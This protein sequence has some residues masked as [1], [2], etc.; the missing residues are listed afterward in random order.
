MKSLNDEIDSKKEL[1]EAI[2]PV[3]YSYK[4]KREEIFSRTDKKELQDRLKGIKENAINHLMQ[5]KQEA[6]TALQNNG[7][8]V[9]EAKDAKAARKAI[10]EI[11]GDE[12][13]I[14][15]S[16]SNAANEIGLRDAL[17]DKDLIETDLGDFLVDIMREQEIHPVLPAIHLQPQKMADALFRLTGERVFPKPEAILA[18]ARKY[19]RGKITG[20]KVGISGANVITADGT[21]MILENEGNVSLVS[22]IP[23][24]HIIITGFEKIAPTKEDALVIAKSA[25]VY[26]TAQDFPVYVNFI[27]GPSKTAD[28]QDIMLTG[29]QG[30]KEVYV[31]LL[32]NGRSEMLKS[33]FKDVLFCIN[34]GACL[35]FCPV[36]HQIT[37]RYGK[38]YY[39]SRGVLT[40]LFSHSIESAYESG[41][42]FCTLCQ[43]C[44]ENCPAGIDLPALMK[45][46]REKMIKQGI[47][48]EGAAK[49]IN[50]IRQYGNPFGKLKEGEMPK[51]L[52]C[53]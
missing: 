15:K 49:M 19:L 23:E 42:Y 26:G 27:S 25:A 7:F 2:L 43:A 13:K 44:K 45:L 17:K 5:L 29:A 33:D 3:V 50:N 35:N 4:Q 1:K 6:I 46:L 48:P 40:A 16:K 32:D 10:L 12:K 39:G 20:A 38:E 22:R 53:C 21:V 24:K 28:I 9:V 51:G 52:Y 34:C 8:K 18:S 47:Q 30:A 31:I 37:D 14:I 36:Y 41:A 11:I